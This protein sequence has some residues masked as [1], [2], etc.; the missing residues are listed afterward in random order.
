MAAIKRM[1]KSN[2]PLRFSMGVGEVIRPSA[3]SLLQGVTL[4]TTYLSDVLG[5]AD[6]SSATINNI[7]KRARRWSQQPD[8]PFSSSVGLQDVEEAIRSL[9]FA[10]PLKLLELIQLGEGVRRTT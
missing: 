2:I 5:G 3:Q 4:A 1:S 7:K 6:L 8:L 10:S 9:L